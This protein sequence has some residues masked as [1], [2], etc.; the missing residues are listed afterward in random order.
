MPF[1]PLSTVPTH[2]AEALLRQWIGLD[3]RSVG[4]TAIA[5]AVQLR[6]TDC[7]ETAEAR[8][9]ARLTSDTAE[10]NRLIDAVVVSESWFFRD[11]AVF[12]FLQVFAA[13]RPQSPGQPPLRI[14]SVPCAAGEEPYSIAI[15]LLEAGLSVEA[16]RIDAV[17]VSHVNVA[18][19]AAATYSD[20]AFHSGNLSLRQRWFR[21]TGTAAVLDE[22]VR[23]P[24]HF[25]QGNLLDESFVAAREPYDV[26][27]CRN[28]LIY[29]TDEARGR[30]EQT[31]DRLLTPDGLLVLGAAEP[32]SFKDRWVPAANHAVFTLRRRPQPKHV[33]E[34]FVA[35]AA[36]MQTRFAAV[37]QSHSAR[38]EATPLASS[39]VAQPQPTSIAVELRAVGELAHRGDHAAA[40]AA[41]V[42]L[43]QAGEP[44]PE[45]FFMMGMLHQATGDLRQAEA[46]LQKTL[47]LDANHDEAVLALALI[48]TKQG[49]S[50]R[51]EQYRQTAARITARKGTS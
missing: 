36:A 30:A 28:L 27:F 46:C 19:A 1:T 42:Q 12:D 33:R 16:F 2:P 9:I 29:F 5:R 50:R 4:S 38:D 47:Y 14:L 35:P 49:D 51:A 7:G 37:S 48:A 40:L 32:P 20:N 6:M 3:A 24:V 44:R 23:R 45:V 17:D 39:V 26:I 13:A 31:L 22:A 43:Q 25:A 10:K 34:P 15:A 41:C 21:T 18:R 11:P 8:Y